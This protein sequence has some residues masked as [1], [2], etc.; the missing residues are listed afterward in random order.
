MRAIVALGVFF[1]VGNALAG[2][3]SE[4]QAKVERMSHDALTSALEK[5]PERWTK[6][7]MKYS[8]H[9]DPSGRIHD[10]RIVSDLPNRWADDTARH[11]LSI[12]KLPRVPDAVMQQTEMEG[13]DAEA[14]LILAKKK[15]DYEKLM[16]DAQR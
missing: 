7:P 14:Q 12:L 5:H 2:P 10:I 4:Y 15:A 16:K 1:F 9:I 3:V 8:F 13:P 11:A 6:L